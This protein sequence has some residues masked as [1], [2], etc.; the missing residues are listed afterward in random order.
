MRTAT[1][2]EEFGTVEGNKLQVSVSQNGA[3][4]L[5]P[6]RVDSRNRLEDSC[7]TFHLLCSSKWTSFAGNHKSTV[8]GRKVAGTFHA[9]ISDMRVP[10]LMGVAGAA[11]KQDSRP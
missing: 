4:L 11:G 10:G 1:V 8:A 7:C 6:Q 2:A 3:L 5:I 9:V